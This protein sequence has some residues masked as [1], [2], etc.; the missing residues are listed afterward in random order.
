MYNDDMNINQKI[1]E[2][3]KKVEKKQKIEQKDINFIIN[4]YVN[5]KISDDEILPFIKAIYNFGLDNESLFYLTDAMKNSGEILNL[6]SL[7]RCVDKHSTGGVS[8]TTT[9]IIVPILAELGT[10]ILKLSGR[11]LGFTGGTC[12][13]LESF[14]GYQTD[15]DLNKAIELTQKNGGC[16][17]TS[18]KNIA[19]ADKKI[20]ALR[21]R[22]GLV[23]SIPLIAS[24][25]MSKKLATNADILILDVKYGNGAFMKSKKDAEKLGKIMKNIGKF[26][27]KEVKITYGKMN[28][29]LGYNVGPKLECMEAIDVLKG[30]QCN[31][32]LYKESV[33]LASLCYSL[34][35]KIPYVFAKIKV[36]KCIKSGRALEKLKQI[37][38]S[39]GGNLDLFKLEY[40]YPTLK[41]TAE[42]SGK[43]CGFNTQ[44][45]G[46]IIAKLN[47]ENKD[48]SLG[49]R[50]FVKIGDKIKAKD[51]LFYVYAKDLTQAEKIKN[52]V[53]ECIFIKK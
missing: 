34:D 32:L 43:I 17:I 26:A 52:L 37:V 41:V 53:N 4:S 6:E 12:D 21:D 46:E 38:L 47:F 35:K 39:Q 24:S 30:N 14:M 9:I 36:I 20:Y 11:S 22:T 19:P 33:K 13:K 45:I 25:I 44:K 5:E 29:P 50:T 48:N 3:V 16:M 7:K 10:K 15:L 1:E 8:D 23:D 49:I 27:K 18:S 31:S 2:I 51:N 28:Q 42:S 40:S